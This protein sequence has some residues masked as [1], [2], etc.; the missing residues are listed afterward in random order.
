[1]ENLTSLLEKE[2]SLHSQNEER[3]SFL[4][5]LNPENWVLKMYTG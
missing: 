1:M 5:F 2:F 4:E 3:N